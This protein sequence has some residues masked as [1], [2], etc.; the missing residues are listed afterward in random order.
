M[1][2]FN[3]RPYL[4]AE[5]GVNHN[6]S[7]PLALKSIELAA[8]SGADAVKFQMFNTEEFMSDKKINYKYKTNKGFKSENMFKMFNERPVGLFERPW[9]F[10][11]QKH[12][13]ALTVRFPIN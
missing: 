10:F 1:K 2:F 12:A 4:I 5:I 11:S 7:L 13:N 9:T 3:K 6:G 8:K